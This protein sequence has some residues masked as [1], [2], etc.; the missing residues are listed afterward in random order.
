MRTLALSAILA[1]SVGCA[2][3]LPNLDV[4]LD[5]NAVSVSGPGVDATVGVTGA[6]VKT[7]AFQAGFTACVEA[8]GPF[9]PV[10]RVVPF[11]GDLVLKFISCPAE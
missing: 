6:S 8:D 4:A 5:G 9:A 3:Q 1:L 2:G 10:L 11:V 7:P